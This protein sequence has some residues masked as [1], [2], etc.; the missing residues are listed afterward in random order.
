MKN[1]ILIFLFGHVAQ[2]SGLLPPDRT[3][4]AV[5]ARVCLCAVLWANLLEASSRAGGL[6][7]FNRQPSRGFEASRV[8]GV[9]NGTAWIPD[10]PPTSEERQKDR[11]KEKRANKGQ[12][13][14]H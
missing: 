14:T 12:A 2:S 9:S 6:R 3:E 1:D 11:K 13:Y 4:R 7:G 8:P 10:S 5:F